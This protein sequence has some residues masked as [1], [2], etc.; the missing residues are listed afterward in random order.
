METLE[1]VL[2]E[3]AFFAGMDPE[4][5]HL[6]VG[7]ASNVRFE[8][9]SFIF[10]QGE[11]ARHFYLIRQGKAALEMAPPN[12][13]PMMIQT[14]SEGDVLGWSWLIPPHRWRFDAR[15]LELTRAFAMDGA[16]LRQKCGQDP[17]LGYELLRRFSSIIAERL[18]ATCLQLM[19]VYAIQS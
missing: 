9:G 3:H 7:C 4:Y 15:A 8:A 17:R 16:C 11:E 13:P 2:S 1:R 12:R 14:V 10:R 6:L 19:D 18:E 5:V